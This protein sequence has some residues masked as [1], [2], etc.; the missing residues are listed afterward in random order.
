[1]RKPAPLLFILCIWITAS[2][3]GGC[4]GNY[5][6]RIPLRAEAYVPIYGHNTALREITG[7]GPEPTKD[8][9][10]IY[11]SGKRLYQ[12]ENNK[13]IHIIDYTD[14]TNPRKLAFINIAGCGEVTVKNNALISNCLN[15]IVTIDISD[16]EHP[17]ELTR[18]REAFAITSYY[19]EFATQQKPPMP[20]VYYVCPNGY[21]GDVIGWKLEKQVHASCKTN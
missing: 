8:A 17:K 19:N 1:M 13:G 21:Q 14:E 15:D 4:Y 3:I 20:N 5:N 11:V 2:F 18:V 12:V 9:G 7:S 10:K 16:P 6:Y